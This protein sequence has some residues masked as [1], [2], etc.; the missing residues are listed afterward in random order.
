MA[1]FR[2][3]M[4]NCG[5]IDM[6]FVGSRF[7]WSNKFTKERLDR[8]F[9][10]AQ[11]RSRF[12][13]RR[14]ITLNPSDSDHAPILVEVK[15][16]RGLATKYCKRFRFEECWHGRD[17]CSNIINQEWGKTTA[18]NALRQLETKIQSAGV[19][20][21]EWHRK[22]FDQQKVEIRVIQEKLNDFMRAPFSPQ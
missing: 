13:Y 19:R 7:T 11:W 16:K 5:L 1:K 14:T 20:L 2:S 6:G 4:A 18:G 12:P 3:T 15:S 9:Q 22:E 21:M 10:S 8:S 17:E